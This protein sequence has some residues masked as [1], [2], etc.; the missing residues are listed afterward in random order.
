MHRNANRVFRYL[1][2]TFF[3]VFVSL[4]ISQSTGYFE[5]RS[6][7]KVALTKSQIEKFE[8]DIKKG[9][10]VDV[11]KYISFNNRSY[12]NGIS[13]VGLS[14]SKM[15]EKYIQKIINGSF[16]LLGNLVGS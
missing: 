16:K 7:K 4:Y 2:F 10:K 13:K 15:S 8:S 1:L 11:D 5:Y 9:K 6:S 12:Q 14:L 3:I